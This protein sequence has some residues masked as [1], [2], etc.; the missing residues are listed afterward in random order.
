MV[1]VGRFFSN[2]TTHQIPN[3]TKYNTESNRRFLKPNSMNNF[4]KSLD[5][6]VAPCLPGGD[7]SNTTRRSTTGLNF[8]IFCGKDI[9]A[10]DISSVD[11]LSLSEC[12]DKCISLGIPPPAGYGFSYSNTSVCYCKGRGL[13]GKAPTVD[14]AGSILAIAKESEVLLKP[15]Q[16]LCPYPNLS[17]T[18]R[19]GLKFK[20]FCGANMPQD[21][22]WPWISPTAPG[23]TEFSVAV[24][25]SNFENCMDF[26][27]ASHPLCRG[28]VY[29]GIDYGYMNCFLKQISHNIYLVYSSG[30][31]I[32]HS[33]VAIVSDFP[34]IEG[35]S[36]KQGEILRTVNGTTFETFCSDFRG[37]NNITASHELTLEKC[38]EN[39]ANYSPPPE[40]PSCVGVM[41][42]TGFQS[43][44]DNCYLK[45]GIGPGVG[46]D[47]Y[48][49]AVIDTFAGTVTQASK[50]PK[51]ANGGRR[52]WIAAP[53]VGG[54][55]LLVLG[56]VYWKYPKSRNPSRWKWRWGRNGE[57]AQPLL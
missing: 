4:N 5:F 12:A 1:W 23:R 10:Y 21:D 46:L 18:T 2:P 57:S 3:Q 11:G 25:A 39:C 42:D 32:M 33:A 22:Y 35:W 15:E 36:C 55:V 47:N 27:V 6:S 49:L 54:V 17:T 51:N 37:D 44:W 34:A 14:E 13:V 7:G 24:H 45:S 40:A 8:D 38:L 41:F 29:G 26:C 53:V 48:T 52:D 20:I 9:I 19:R 30:I 56:F 28:A 50:P 31:Y 16:S 43:G